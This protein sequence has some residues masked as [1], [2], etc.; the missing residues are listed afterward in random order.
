MPYI[1]R[2]INNLSHGSKMSNETCVLVASIKHIFQGRVPQWE[3]MAW[4]VKIVA[5]M[6]GYLCHVTSL[7]EPPVVSG[8]VNHRNDSRCVCVWV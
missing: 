1:K 6:T 4:R 7:P 2:L 5:L 3:Q 8:V